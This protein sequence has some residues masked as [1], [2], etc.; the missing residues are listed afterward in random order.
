MKNTISTIC[1]ILAIS[2]VG[3]PSFAQTP[4]SD[5]IRQSYRFEKDGKYQQALKAM[6]GMSEVQASYFLVLRRGWLLYLSGQ[7]ED[8]A[9]AYAKA[10]RQEPK[11]I[12]PILGQMLPVMALRR[13]KDA[14][15]LGRKVLKTAPNNYLANSRVAW[16]DYNLGRFTDA[17]ARYQAVLALFPGDFEMRSGYAWSLLKL[18]E[19]K[20]AFRQFQAALAM[21]PD[22]G[23]AQTGL[24]LAK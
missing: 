7:Y 19:K 9:R 5:A 20:A 8:S 14:A 3:R 15:A 11:A 22:Y 17:K 18:G 1:L 10:V 24:S 13:W 23:S 4:D 16:C 21:A 2:L 6:A 12:E